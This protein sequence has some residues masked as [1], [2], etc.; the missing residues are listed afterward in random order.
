MRRF[1]WMLRPELIVGDLAA[2]FIIW[3][4]ASPPPTTFGGGAASS[5]PWT[6]WLGL[7]IALFGLGWMHVIAWQVR[8]RS[9]SMG[10]P[11]KLG[12]F[13]TRGMLRLA[14]VSVIAV[15]VLLLTPAD[16]S[17]G[18]EPSIAGLPS[19]I[20]LLLL[21]LPVALIG[22]TWMHRIAREGSEPEAFDQH[23]WSRA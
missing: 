16:P 12:W 17:W 23:W 22:A 20:V 9:I 4:I 8:D 15:V 3:I 7:A 19:R 21:A 11:P 10:R 6:V 18:M 2:L 13:A 1:E 14:D 5:L